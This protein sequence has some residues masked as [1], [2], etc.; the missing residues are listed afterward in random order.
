MATMSSAATRCRSA[1]RITFRGLTNTVSVHV[2][3]RGDGGWKPC[4]VDAPLRARPDWWRP[5]PAP[6]PAGDGD[7]PGAWAGGAYL[8]LSASTGALAD[9]HDVLS[10]QVTLVM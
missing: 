9:N 5:V 1:A 3:A 4:V 7:G 10:L 8:G 6:G 2:D